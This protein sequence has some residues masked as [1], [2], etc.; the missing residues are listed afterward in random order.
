MKIQTS[1][2]LKFFLVL[3]LVLR[4]NYLRRKKKKSQIFNFSE[5]GQML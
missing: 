2:T 4:I 1:K 3:V 5:L